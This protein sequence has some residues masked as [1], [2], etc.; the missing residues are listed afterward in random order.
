MVWCI[1]VFSTGLKS[2][3]IPFGHELPSVGSVG[4]EVREGHN[5][6][7]FFVPDQELN[8][9]RIIRQQFNT[10]PNEKNITSIYNNLNDF[11]QKNG[12]L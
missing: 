7:L 1:W 5:P 8:Q 2:S 12:P 4:S 9:N 11:M 6:Q 10:R 3:V